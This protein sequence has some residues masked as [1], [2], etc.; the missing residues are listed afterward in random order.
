ML[1]RTIPRYRA[2]L[3]HSFWLH[4]RSYSYKEKPEWGLGLDLGM[5]MQ[6]GDL[7]RNAHVCT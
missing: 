2:V 5:A 7:L 6:P 3:M 1:C 4:S